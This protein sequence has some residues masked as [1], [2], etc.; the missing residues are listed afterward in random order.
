MGSN[1]LFGFVF[2]GVFLIAGVWTLSEG[3]ADWTATLGTGLLML[4]GLCLV[5]ALVAPGLLQ[6]PNRAWTAFGNLLH[7]IVS[8]LVLGVLWLAVITPT[9]LVRRLIGSDSLNR[10]FDLEAATYWIP[11]DPPGPSL[12]DQ[13]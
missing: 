1:R 13:F 4:S 11:R 6:G 9:G 12:K 10:A 3:T 7:R 8:P 2:T 5:L